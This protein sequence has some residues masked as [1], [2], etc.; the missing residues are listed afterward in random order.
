MTTGV[1]NGATKSSDYHPRNAGDKA[2]IKSSSGGSR[3]LNRLGVRL[4][5]LKWPFI[6]HTVKG[7]AEFCHLARKNIILSE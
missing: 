2:R 4:V 7:F 3:R 5:P 6:F 1:M